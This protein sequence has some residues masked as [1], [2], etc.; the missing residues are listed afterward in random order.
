MQASGMVC[1]RPA[2][3]LV[4]SPALPALLRRPGSLAV[5]AAR[6]CRRTAHTLSAARGKRE[7]E[8]TARQEA[9]ES[10]FLEP[11]V[12]SLVLGLGAAV[13][14]ESTHEMLQLLSRSAGSSSANMV[15]MLQALPPPLFVADHV[16]AIAGWLGFYLIEAVA[17]AAVLKSYAGDQTAAAPALSRLTTLPKKMLPL[18]LQLVKS[19]LL[20]S[21]GLEAGPAPAG[22]AAASFAPAPTPDASAPAAA[23]KLAPTASA[24]VV[25]EERGS[26][27]ATLPRPRYPPTLPLPKKAQ[28]PARRPK[29]QDR[30]LPR[31]EK[32]EGGSN[33]VPG[34][35]TTAPGPTTTAEPGTL[36]ARRKRRG[37]APGAWDPQAAALA[38]LKREKELLE[39]NGYLT[40]CWYAVAP[41]SAVQPGKPYKREMLGKQMV[42]F[43]D[44][45][46]KVQCLDNIC[47]HRA[48]P[49]DQ[50]W[51]D[52]VDGHDCVVCPYHAWAFS[53]DGRLRDVPAL[54]NRGEWPKRP[55][56]PSYPI[57]EKGGFIWLFYG[58]PS[59]PEEQRPPIPFTPEL[60]DPE[61][62]V[63]YGEVE[64]DA[65]HASV[66][67]NA[68]DFAHIHYVH[69]SS[70]G[71]DEQ[72]KLRNM[73]VVRDEYHITATFDL[74]NKP[75]NAL[76]DW[77]KVPEVRI[78]ARAFV[79]S[80]SF[81]A[82]RL[83]RGLEFVTFVNTVP[84][85]AN[86]S[87]NIYALARKWSGDPT[88]FVFNLPLW[89]TFADSA[90]QKIQGEDRVIL[91]KVRPDLLP[92]EFSLAPDMAQV[93]FRKMRREFVERGFWEPNEV[94][95]KRITLQGLAQ[96]LNL[97][98]ADF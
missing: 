19:L 48:A 26:T 60:E 11:F 42:V 27:E 73:K 86:R 70:F 16:A 9:A 87:V 5:P 46:G 3:A 72:P 10:P 24:F 80:S 50:G 31:I 39:R 40:N 51:L 91:D 90:M 23:P 96:G 66:F 93:A 95:A 47:P 13:V 2:A 17:I 82:F 7:V 34:P 92:R 52:K 56:V 45:Q 22:A 69:G 36:V 79:P 89:D 18:R 59:M 25:T 85:D 43:R 65:A 30:T 37:L 94:D 62:Q 32:P 20:T 1:S 8:L 4:A 44:S 71:N 63:V 77:S 53:G 29:A 98:S 81:I 88:G 58:P 6:P 75:V 64:F 76:W 41:S 68:T 74:H 84:I 61:W 15:E 33:I 38:C 28:G 21:A 35:T 78:L 57:Q 67:D 54:E 55:I 12:R 49:L 14:L 97:A 83:A